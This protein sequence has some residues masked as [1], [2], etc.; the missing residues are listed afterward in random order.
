MMNKIGNKIIAVNIWNSFS[1]QCMFVWLI[2]ELMSDILLFYSKIYIILEMATV[3]LFA[4]CGD[5]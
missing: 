5:I 2:P 4:L 3:M 1:Q